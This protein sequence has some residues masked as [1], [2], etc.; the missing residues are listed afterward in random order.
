M[1]S[2]TEGAIANASTGKAEEVGMI[3]DSEEPGNTERKRS[4][5]DESQTACRDLN[6][7]EK[8]EI[9]KEIHDSPTGGHAGINRTYRKLKHFINWAG[10]KSGVDNYLRVCEKC[11]KIK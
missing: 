8:I 7:K 5:E 1:F 6:E 9:L 11:Q 2:E 3:P 4:E 10:M